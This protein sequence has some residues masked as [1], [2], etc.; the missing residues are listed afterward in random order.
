[1][2]R[3]S[4]DAMKTKLRLASYSICCALMWTTDS[5]AS[6][7]IVGN[8]I[9]YPQNAGSVEVR[10]KNN[11]NLPYVIQ[12][13]VDTGNTSSTPEDSTNVPFRIMPP[14]VKIAAYSGQ[15]IRLNLIGGE[16]LPGNKESLFWL[17]TL[18]IPPA[19]I[20]GATE[21]NSILFLI[22]NR[23]KLFYRPERIGNPDKLFSGV[24]VRVY[25]ST[26]LVINNNR[27]WFL[28]LA[29]V[30]V[31]DSKNTVICN[32]E[33]LAPYSSKSL[34]CHSVL[35]SL[36]APIKISLSAFNDQGARVSEFFSSQ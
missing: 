33:T 36:N 2:A 26:K 18:Q 6:V 25:D 31:S 34:R 4:D 29:N 12:A 1:M 20:E 28:S 3:M 19:N 11:D 16:S 32:A 23:I 30:S 21:K 17:N 7:T 8:R 14:L 22:R 10:L 27:P 9:V 35:Q 24:Q 5:A 15:S 13:W